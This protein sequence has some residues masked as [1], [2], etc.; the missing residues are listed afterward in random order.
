M[1]AFDRDR[2]RGHRPTTVLYFDAPDFDSVLAR[3]KRRGVTLE[4]PVEIVQRTT[5]GQLKL[6]QFV[7]TDGNALAILGLVPPP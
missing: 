3:L 7:D 2:S 1:I 4:G 5:A 6:Q